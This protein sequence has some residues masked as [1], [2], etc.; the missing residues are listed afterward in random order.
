MC[1]H[2]QKHFT[3]HLW[4][5]SHLLIFLCISW[6]ADN[7]QKPRKTDASSIASVKSKQDIDGRPDEIFEIVQNP[8]VH[9]EEEGDHA[10]ASP[11]FTN[12]PFHGIARS[13]EESDE[14]EVKS[15][16][17]EPSVPV[18]NYYIKVS[19]ASI[20][21]SIFNK[22]GD[23][24]ASCKLESISI[25]SYYLE[26]VC[27]IVQEL[28]RTKFS[29]KMSKSKVRELLAILN[30]VESSEMNVGWLHSILNEVAEAVESG[31]QHWTLD[32]A[33]ANCDHELKLTKKE[34]ESRME[35]LTQKE[36]EMRNA[37]AKVANTRAHLS[38]LESKYF[39]LNE[40][41]SSLQLKVNNLQSKPLA[42]ELL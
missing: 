35:D 24:A 41:I 32:A 14:E 5:N 10:T 25:R 2:A 6:Q 28:Q 33:K 27:C 17:S 8:A 1:A 42:D 40:A 9:D 18:G 16:S 11:N 20:L 38:E 7:F 23:I 30:D 13:H 4:F 12:F 31:G 34:L 21:Q 39:Q 37:K 3:F 22:R 26:C 29:Q 19:L 15:A 36:K